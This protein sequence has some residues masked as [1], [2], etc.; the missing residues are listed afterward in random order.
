M[1]NKRDKSLYACGAWFGDKFADN[2][3]YFYL[4]LLKSGKNAVWVTRN[5]NVY[6]Q[7][8]EEDLP[9]VLFGTKES[10]QV[11]SK[12]K[13]V[14]ISTSS[15]D[16]EAQYIGGATTINLWHGIP[17]KKIVYDD[18]VTSDLD[19]LHKKIWCKLNNFPNRN[20]YYFSTSDR[21][22]EIYKGC[23]RTDE[24][25]I[26]QTGQARNDVFF[27]GTFKK[28]EYANIAY[29]KLVVYMPTHRN[30]GKTPVDIYSLFNLQELNEYCE[31][32]NILFLIKKHYYNRN[33][34][35]PIEGYSNIV[36]FTEI[37]CDTQEILFNADVLITD[38]SSCYIDY[39]LLDHPIIFYAY[40]YLEYLKKDREMYFEY[41]DV[42]PG[43][44]VKTF[45]EFM[46]ALDNAINGNVEYKEEMSRIKNLFY[47]KENQNVVCPTLLKE[48]EKL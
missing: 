12:A 33:D 8:K 7:L 44:K 39:L 26:I 20:T 29:D 40:D 3:K 19:K 18:H 6:S 25:H 14:V 24:K 2:S 36:D 47:S 35:A 9:V 4:Y 5:K 23:F 38:Y 41:D 34:G 13:Y 15:G 45:N 30:E 37:A 21:I 11:C 22:S 28:K 16:V 1:L 46:C 27:D 42:T 43:P 32:K 10:K 48:I 31:R 17:L